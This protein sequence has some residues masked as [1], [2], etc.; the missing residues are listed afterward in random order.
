VVVV[1]GGRA[2]ACGGAALG[3]WATKRAASGVGGR[4][5]KVG[6]QGSG[7]VVRGFGPVVL[8]LLFALVAGDIWDPGVLVSPFVP[9]RSAGKIR[10]ARFLGRIRV[11]RRTEVVDLICRNGARVVGGWVAE[12]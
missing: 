5:K 1:V 12:M 9:M 7:F 2:E 11:A 8:S 10:R 4:R 6:C 3:G